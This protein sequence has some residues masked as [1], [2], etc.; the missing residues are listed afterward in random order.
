MTGFNKFSVSKFI[1]IYTIGYTIWIIPLLY[2]FQILFPLSVKISHFFKVFL[3]FLVPGTSYY[4]WRFYNRG[5]LI[6]HIQNE[7]ISYLILSVFLF[8]SYSITELVFH[9]VNIN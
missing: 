7:D 2:I 4:I 9:R 3:I 5:D 8:I 1:L 6:Q